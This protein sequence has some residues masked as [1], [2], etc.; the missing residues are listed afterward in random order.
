MSM[1]Q[2]ILLH[3]FHEDD[4][5]SWDCPCCGRGTLSLV[6]NS[7]IKKFSVATDTDHPAFDPEWIDYIFQMM[8]VCANASCKANVVCS[9]IGGV[10][11]EY[12]H[13]GSGDWDWFEYFQPKHFEPSLKLFSIPPDVPEAVS[14]ELDQSFS[15]FFKY[16]SM[17]LVSL[18]R[19]LEILLSELGVDSNGAKGRFLTLADRIKLLPE[20]NKAI[21][22]PVTAINGSVMME[23]TVIQ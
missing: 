9:G 12:L 17:S 18:R 4:I 20:A 19:S 2:K 14:D 7:F 3:S 11:Q 21:I 1:D 16:P 10:E 13:D 22:D 6:E 15:V 5:P 23:H 8:L